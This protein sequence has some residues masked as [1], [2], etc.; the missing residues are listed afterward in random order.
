MNISE[1]QDGFSG[2]F[3][4]DYTR[5][6]IRTSTFFDLFWEEN[7]LQRKGNINLQ[8]PRLLSSCIS[9]AVQKDLPLSEQSVADQIGFGNML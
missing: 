3:H 4:V 2:A 8:L 7:R 5:R 1:P 6:L 9:F